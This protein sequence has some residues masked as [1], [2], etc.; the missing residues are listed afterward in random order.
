MS[1]AAKDQF[2]DYYD[3]IA[4]EI[5][6]SSN[7]LKRSEVFNRETSL[8]SLNCISSTPFNDVKVPLGYS[9]LRN[10]FDHFSH[11]IFHGWETAPTKVIYV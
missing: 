9:S 8:V 11:C 2:K 10:K 6:Q 3:G 7:Q 1:M 5:V 4:V